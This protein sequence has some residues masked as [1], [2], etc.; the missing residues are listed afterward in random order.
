MSHAMGLP[1]TP[2]LEAA[3]VAASERHGLQTYYRDCVRPLLGAPMD[4]WPSCCGGGCEPCNAT[5][6]AV[7]RTV[8]EHLGLDDASA[9]AVAAEPE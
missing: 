6:T 1:R 9:Q 4:R 3:L 7:A 8:Y 2:E 5:L